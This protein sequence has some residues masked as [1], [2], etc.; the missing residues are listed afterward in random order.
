MRNRDTY[1]RREMK[2]RRKMGSTPKLGMQ[3]QH[4]G[5]VNSLKRLVSES[6]K[7]GKRV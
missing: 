1:T 3:A 6:E 5:R 2:R 4:N 7:G